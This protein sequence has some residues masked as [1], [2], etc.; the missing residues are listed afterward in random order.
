MILA[1]S[2]QNYWFKSTTWFYQQLELLKHGKAKN[3]SNIFPE[4]KFFFPISPVQLNFK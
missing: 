4:Q 1:G 3:I 2:L